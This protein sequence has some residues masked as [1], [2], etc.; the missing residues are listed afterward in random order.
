MTGTLF[1]FFW[2]WGALGSPIKFNH[3]V[4]LTKELQLNLIVFGKDNTIFVALVN[5]TVQ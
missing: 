3:A 1:F 4:A 2:W 5:T